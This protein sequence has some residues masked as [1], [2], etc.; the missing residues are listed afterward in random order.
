MLDPVKEHTGVDIGAGAEKAVQFLVDPDGETSSE[1]NARFTKEAEAANE[2]HAD[3]RVAMQASGLD[4]E[5]RSRTEAEKDEY[6]AIVNAK[7][8][9]GEWKSMIPPLVA[10]AKAVFQEGMRVI[11]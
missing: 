11:E 3:F 2:A 5:L 7:D 6:N 1:A 9:G 4:G 10:K 8:A